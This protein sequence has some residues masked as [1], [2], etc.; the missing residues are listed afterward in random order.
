MTTKRCQDLEQGFC[1]DGQHRLRVAAEK[2]VRFSI[3][4]GMKVLWSTVSTSF[5]PCVVI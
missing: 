1:T 3:G 2:G 4:C 5:L